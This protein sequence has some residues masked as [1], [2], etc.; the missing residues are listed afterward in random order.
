MSN[1]FYVSKTILLVMEVS[2]LFNTKPHFSITSS[3]ITL[4]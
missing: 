2:V 3:P 4:E 1:V